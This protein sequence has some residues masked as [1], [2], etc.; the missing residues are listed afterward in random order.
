MP[1]TLRDQTGMAMAALLAAMTVMAIVL[2]VALPS[3]K[4]GAI[5]AGA[6]GGIMGVTSKSS[7]TSIRAGR[8]TGR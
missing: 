5:T 1:R 6:P 2:S 7:D 8:G 3:W 4:R